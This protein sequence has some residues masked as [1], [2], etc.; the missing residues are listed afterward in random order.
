LTILCGSFAV[1]Q[2]PVFDGLS[3]G[4]FPFQQDG[5]PSFEIDTGGGEIAKGP[6][7]KFMRDNNIW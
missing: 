6:S 5:L 4:P 1:L 3:F 2:A 7:G